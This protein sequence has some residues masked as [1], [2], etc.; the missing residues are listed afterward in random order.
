MLYFYSLGESPSEQCFTVSTYPQFLKF[1]SQPAIISTTDLSSTGAANVVE[2]NASH[3][4]RKD[5]HS[6]QHSAFTP[7]DANR[8]TFIT[9]DLFGNPPLG[10]AVASSTPV[11]RSLPFTVKPDSKP[12]PV[13]PRSYC[14]LDTEGNVPPSRRVSFG[15][16]RAALTFGSGCQS[17]SVGR[18]EVESGASFTP[19]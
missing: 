12:E 9:P 14:Q 16:V 6:K 13:P 5:I 7:I 18:E 10:K 15:S 4:Q 17:N 2:N 19:R 8:V 1:I 11:Q 3:T